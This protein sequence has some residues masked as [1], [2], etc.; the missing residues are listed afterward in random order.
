M[1]N[2][3]HFVRKNS[4]LKA[5]FIY[6][7]IVNHR[8]FTPFIV[9]RKRVDKQFDGGFV[10]NDDFKF[11]ELD[12]SLGE[13]VYEKLIYKFFKKLSGRQRQILIKFINDNNIKICHL[14]YATDAFIYLPALK[15]VNIPKVV[16]VYGY[17]SSGF[18][19]RFLGFGK[20]LLKNRTFR[21][22]TKVFSMSPDMKSDLISAGCPKEKVIVHYY[23]TDVQKFKQ[24]HIFRDENPVKFLIISGL[25]PQKG[26]KFL[27]QAFKK[28]YESNPDISLSIFGEG[29]ERYA[30]ESF[31][32]LYKMESYVQLLGAVVYGSQQHMDSFASHDV[33]IHPSVTD[34]NGD[35]E[36]IPGAIVEA[37]AA[38]LPIISTYHAG[39]PYIIENEKSG[40]L[41]KE[42]DIDALS[43]TILSLSSD[44]E[45]RKNLAIAAQKFAL[46][47]LDLIVKEK[48]LEEIYKS[49]ITNKCV[50]SA[51]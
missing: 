17:E 34:I 42:W 14:H 10:K 32:R 16:S 48:E 4:Q 47:N 29:S 26:H 39:I 41:V 11:P 18:P 3:C 5:S 27:L 35:K 51:E 30:I 12:L 43:K 46:T 9:Y 25:T 24:T 50:E 28:A 45:E 37:M 22:A 19:R 31:I 15:N 6:N 44:S 7:Q 38:G 20:R 23:G 33:F 8:D 13:S 40:L 36:G 21:Y 1:K 2:V 49:L